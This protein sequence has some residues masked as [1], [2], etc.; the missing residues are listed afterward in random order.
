ML[1]QRV[2]RKSLYRFRTSLGGSSSA[3]C[4]SQH[5]VIMR[6][7]LIPIKRNQKTGREK[8][9]TAHHIKHTTITQ[10]STPHNHHPNAPCYANTHYTDTQYSTTLHYIP[11]IPHTTTTSHYPHP[12][13]HQHSYTNTC[14]TFTLHS[15][16]VPTLITHVIFYFAQKLISKTYMPHRRQPRYTI[17]SIRLSKEEIYLTSLQSRSH[18]PESERPEAANKHRATHM[19]A[20]ERIAPTSPRAPTGARAQARGHAHNIHSP[21]GNTTRHISGQPE[22]ASSTI[23]H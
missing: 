3:G 8:N 7:R 23:R 13:L 5:F 14:Y 18:A 16:G 2:T 20:F 9:A 19:S 15:T 1:L 12:M 6:I 22:L 4:L 11:H 21:P 17:S 10:H